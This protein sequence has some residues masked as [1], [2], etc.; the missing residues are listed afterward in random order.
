MR[1]NAAA[2]SCGMSSGSA[3]SSRKVATMVDPSAAI[4]AGF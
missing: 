4:A 1:I 2:D 3:T